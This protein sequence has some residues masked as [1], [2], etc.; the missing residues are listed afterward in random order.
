LDHRKCS[1]ELI[2]E[3]H[4]SKATEKNILKHTILYVHDVDLLRRSP[5]RLNFP[6]YDFSAI[7]YDFFNDL[8]EIN[9]KEKTKPPLKT[10][11]NR[12]GR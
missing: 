5:T 7:Y 2:I 8:A 11:Y 9:K 3:K 1:Y 6:F 10:T 12:L 4:R